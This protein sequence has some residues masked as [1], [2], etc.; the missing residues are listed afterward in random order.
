MANDP[1]RLIAYLWLVAQALLMVLAGVA[2]VVMVRVVFRLNWHNPLAPTGGRR[3]STGSRRIIDSA[4]PWQTSAER[5]T[6][7]KASPDDKDQD[8]NNEPFADTDTEDDER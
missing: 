6:V 8:L 7:A 2:V 5:M 1:E 3:G 4:D